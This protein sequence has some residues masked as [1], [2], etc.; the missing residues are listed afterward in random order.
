[1]PQ[2]S[3]AYATKQRAQRLARIASIA[4]A[5]IVAKVTK[6]GPKYENKFKISINNNYDV[7]SDPVRVFTPTKPVKN[8][9][10]RL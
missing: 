8:V 7:E 10:A 9:F 5:S 2:V 6:E 3:S 1:M 4:A